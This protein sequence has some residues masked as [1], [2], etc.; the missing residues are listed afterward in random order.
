MKQQFGCHDLHQAASKLAEVL[1]QQKCKTRIIEPASCVEIFSGPGI[2]QLPAFEQ[3][4]FQLQDATPNRIVRRIN[5]QPG[6]KILDLCAGLG[7]KT[8]QFAE[9]TLDQAQVYASDRNQKKLDKIQQNADRLGLQSIRIINLPEL[10]TESFSRYF[11]VVL[12]DAPCSNTG[13]LARRAEVRWRI[14]EADFKMFAK[15]S[16]ELLEQAKNLVKPAGML[17]YSTCSIEPE[18][19]EQVAEKF[20]SQNSDW[21]ISEQSLTYQ[22]VDPD[23]K[24]TSREGGYR[25]L[26]S[27]Q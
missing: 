24:K 17:A 25:V 8:T 16:L 9:L 2:L 12:I 5:P 6:W 13:V 7:T 19:N 10:F 4:L 27:R 14:K 1:T 21:S 15:G 23:T 22:K 20:V 3:G 18:E 26:F 11:D